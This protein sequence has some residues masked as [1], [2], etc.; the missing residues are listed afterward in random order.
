[1]E[2]SEP[3]L[4]E[5]VIGR[6]GHGPESDGTFRD[7]MTATMILGPFSPR[8]LSVHPE[9]LKGKLRFPPIEISSF[10]SSWSLSSLP[11]IM[12]EHKK[13]PVES[14]GAGSPTA[15]SPANSPPKS[16]GVESPTALPSGAGEETGILPAEHWGELAQA[17]VRIAS[18]LV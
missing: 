3:W 8:T 7:V 2:G 18:G 11:F 6:N 4:V 17:Q 15:K 14:P 13:S 5:N 9:S 16:H 10:I 12:A 1:M